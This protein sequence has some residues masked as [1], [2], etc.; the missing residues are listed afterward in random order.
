[1]KISCGLG[2]YCF[3]L[4]PPS[5]KIYIKLLFQMAIQPPQ[6]YLLSGCHSFFPNDPTSHLCNVE[7]SCM[8]IWVYIWPFSSCL[9]GVCSCAT[10]F[11]FIFL[12]NSLFCRAFLGSQK[13]WAES[14]ES[15][16]IILPTYT[17]CPLLF[18]SCIGLDICYN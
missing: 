5:C 3:L 6:H 4:P 17:K 14:T 9:S 1:M 13:I 8:Y 11:Y 7:N 10:S 15:S 16:H 18:T 12:K 2:C